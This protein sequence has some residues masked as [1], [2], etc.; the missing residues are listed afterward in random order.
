MQWNK[1][2]MSRFNYRAHRF[3]RTCSLNS[4]YKRKIIIYTQ[5]IFGDSV[6]VR[7]FFFATP[8]FVL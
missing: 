7:Y 4:M 2:I 6:T 3:L 1:V 5:Q 8:F